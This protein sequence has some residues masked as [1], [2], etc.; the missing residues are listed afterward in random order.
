MPETG[1]DVRI[2]IW[3]ATG[4]GKTMY[5]ATLPVAGLAKQWTIAG[6]TE[7][8]IQFCLQAEEALARAQLLPGTGAASDELAFSVGYAEMVDVPRTWIDWILGRTRTEKKSFGFRLVVQDHPGGDFHA[9]ADIFDNIGDF[10]SSCD[11][12]VYLFDP[13]REGAGIESNLFYFSA[14]LLRM[15]K[16]AEEN[17]HLVNG[18]LP[19]WFAVCITKYDEIE[20]L[21]KLET[22]GRIIRH[23]GP[24]PGVPIVSDPRGAFRSLTHPQIAGQIDAMFLPERVEYFGTSAIGF[25]PRDGQKV[26]KDDSY[27]VVHT[28]SGA[29]LRGPFMPINVLEPLEWLSHMIYAAR[30]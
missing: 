16:S 11:G 15:R 10:L 25:Y 27:N 1:R 29:R 23:G 17:G 24:L 6:V 5:L 9:Q 3:G 2:G 14:P 30:R 26:V 21:S 7:E 4:S 19:N 20:I 8:S 18:R 28:L 12:I 13:V 22:G